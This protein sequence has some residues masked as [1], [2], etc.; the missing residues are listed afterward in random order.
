MKLSYT[1]IIGFILLVFILGCG[2]VVSSLFKELPLSENYAHI[3]KGAVCR[4]KE[5][6]DGDLSSGVPLTGLP[7]TRTGGLDEDLY[8]GAE[9]VFKEPKRVEYIKVYAVEKTLDRCEIKAYDE[10]T[11]DWKLVAEKKKIL[12]PDFS[13][14]IPR[15]GVVTT[16]IRLLKKRVV[17]TSG[18]GAG[19]GGGRGASGWFLDPEPKVREIEVYSILTEA[20][21]KVQQKSSPEVK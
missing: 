11:D 4:P 21:L 20:E 15:G 17:N 13:I 14:H 9:V 18:G 5:M 19:G 16:Q 2:K 12:S 3:S 1:I 8:V 6:N 10:E 7:A